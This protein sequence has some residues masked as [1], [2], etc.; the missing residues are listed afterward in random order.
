MNSKRSGAM[1]A[2]LIALAGLLLLASCA[3]EK[4]IDPASQQGKQVTIRV[5]MPD[6]GTRVSFTPEEGKLALA[7]GQAQMAAA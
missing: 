2:R 1:K 3:K 7:E 6:P 4:A 5:S